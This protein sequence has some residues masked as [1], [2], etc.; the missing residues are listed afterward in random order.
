MK[1]WAYGTTCLNRSWWWLVQKPHVAVKEY[2][3]LIIEC[4]ACMVWHIPCYLDN[5]LHHS[6]GLWRM[7]GEYINH[8]SFSEQFLHVIKLLADCPTRLCKEPGLSESSF[9]YMLIFCSTQCSVSH[10]HTH[11]P[12]SPPP[13]SSQWCAFCVFCYVFVNKIHK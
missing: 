11:I 7:Y 6:L 2:L 8:S 5:K 13:H 12:P 3:M 4:E 9:I 10:I 1:T